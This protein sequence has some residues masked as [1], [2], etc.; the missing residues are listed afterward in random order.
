MNKLLDNVNSNN[1]VFV[2]VK[3]II[4]SFIMTLVSI[5]ILAAI[6]TYSDLSENLISPI[7]IGITA[8]SILIGTS[9]STIKLSKNGILNGGII[10]FVYIL[11]IYLISSIT[12]TGFGVNTSSIIMIIASIVAGMLGGIVGVNIK[13]INNLKNIV[14]VRRFKQIPL[15]I[16]ELWYL[17]NID[18]RWRTEF[19]R[20]IKN[21]LKNVQKN[22]KLNVIFLDRGGLWKLNF[23][24]YKKVLT[25][26]D[27]SVDI[28]LCLI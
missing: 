23:K 10:G 11:F 7:I 5:F 19:A 28:F 14:K 9:I 16:K 21:F 12:S 18:V 17:T 1:N 25:F 20:V 3:G 8:I 26:F 2:I 13:W 15:F 27:K 6:L 4:I 24:I 22:I